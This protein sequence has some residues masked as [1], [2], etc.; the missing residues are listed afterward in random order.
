MPPPP[1]PVPR[2]TLARNRLRGTTPRINVTRAQYKFYT[3][4][5]TSIYRVRECAHFLRREH[6]DLKIELKNA[7]AQVDLTTATHIAAIRAEL[8]AGQALRATE[9]LGAPPRPPAV[10]DGMID[11]AMK[12]ARLNHSKT[13]R[14]LERA[15]TAREFAR[16]HF[17]NV[18]S[19]VEESA[20]TTKELLEGTL[21]E[22]VLDNDFV[23]P[24]YRELRALL[25]Q[26]SHV[27]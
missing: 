27:V 14:T 22:N 17:S 20:E 4:G 12:L 15:L 11:R 24:T 9:A 6:G 13:K 2:G 1:R 19:D 23:E 10:P 18:E 5:Q 3:S 25:R 7:R 26:A 16:T 8:T 21:Y